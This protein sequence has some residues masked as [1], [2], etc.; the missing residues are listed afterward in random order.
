MTA[1]SFVLRL[2]GVP[3]DHEGFLEFSNAIFSPDIDLSPGIVSGT[4]EVAFTWEA[5]GF[6]EAVAA[7]I[8]HLHRTAPSV[9][10]V[11]VLTED[12]RPIDEAFLDAP[13]PTF[14]VAAA[15]AGK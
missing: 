14:S 1:Y 12:G 11:G 9:T 3:S 5:H 10:V 8:R 13:T 2:D 6:R 4:P 7:A 15:N